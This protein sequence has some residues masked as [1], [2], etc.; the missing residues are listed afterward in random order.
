MVVEV[1][2]MEGWWVCV[3]DGGEQGNSR[4]QGRGCLSYL[5]GGPVG[6]S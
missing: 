1:V 4:V 5:K 6:S 2:E 3:W